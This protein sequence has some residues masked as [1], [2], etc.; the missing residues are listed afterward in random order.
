SP[1]PLDEYWTEALSH[2][3]KS[4][5]ISF[6]SV[7]KS[8][9]LREDIKQSIL[10]TIGSFPD[11]TFIWK[12]EEPK[13]EFGKAASSALPNLVLTSWMPQNDL[14]NDDRIAPFITHGGMGSTLE[15][16]MRGKPGIFIPIF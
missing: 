10:T 15:A 1:R 11:I 7:V 8:V 12:Y 4:I 9:D 14:L 16:A 3:S 13:D 2:R 6:G 5:L